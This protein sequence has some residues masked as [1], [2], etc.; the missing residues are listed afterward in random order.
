MP[1][2]PVHDLESAP[3]A[4]QDLLKGLKEKHGKILNIHGEMAHAPAAI[5]LYVS[6]EDAISGQTSLDL[7]TRKA[8][9]L[10]VS[11]VNGC[12]YC[13]SAYTVGCKRAGFDE[14]Q[15]VAIREGHAG[16]FDGKLSALLDV[17]R[18]I[19]ANTGYVDDGTW[20]AAIDAGWSDTEIL[21]A[22]ADAIRA[23]VTNYFNH[24]TGTEIDMPLAPG[25]DQ[26]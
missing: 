25:L 23:I 12:G 24:L 18:E 7:A 26:E 5:S 17:C 19:A 2:V 4:S 22:F 21:E 9:H 10:A 14:D 20:Q 15:T 13:Q 6:A 8:I 3:S 11:A 16:E 1:R